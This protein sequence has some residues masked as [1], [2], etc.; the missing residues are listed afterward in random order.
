MHSRAL[1][2]FDISQFFAP[3]IITPTKRKQVALVFSSSSPKDL[4]GYDL[5]KHLE[6]PVESFFPKPLLVEEFPRGIP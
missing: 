1:K 6:N 3:E 4:D 5:S 2:A